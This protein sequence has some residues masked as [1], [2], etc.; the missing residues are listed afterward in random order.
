MG[1]LLVPHYPWDSSGNSLC[2]EAGAS[3]MRPLW[4]ERGELHARSARSLASDWYECRDLNPGSGGPLEAIL[5]GYAGAIRDA[6][7][8]GDLDAV[9]RMLDL[10]AALGGEPA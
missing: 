10:L 2:T 5:P 6:L 1:D 8:A 3:M 4:L 9:R 7:E